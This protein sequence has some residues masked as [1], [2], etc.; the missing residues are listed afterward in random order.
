MGKQKQKI[1][2]QKLECSVGRNNVLGIKGFH[3]E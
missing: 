2:I 1:R 3:E